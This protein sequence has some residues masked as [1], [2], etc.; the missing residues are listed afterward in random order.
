MFL[1]LYVFVA[2]CHIFCPKI[3]QSYIEEQAKSVVFV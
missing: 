1:Y 3:F 2:D